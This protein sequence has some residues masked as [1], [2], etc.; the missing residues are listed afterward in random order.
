[1]STPKIQALG[2]T[3]QWSTTSWK[4]SGDVEGIGW[5]EAW[6]TELIEAMEALQPLAAQRGAE[7]AE[8]T[9]EMYTEENLQDVTPPTRERVQRVQRDR[10]QYR[11]ELALIRSQLKNPMLSDAERQALRKRWS[12]VMGGIRSC[13]EI[14]GDILASYANGEAIDRRERERDASQRRLVDADHRPPG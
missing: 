10:E 12:N 7:Q 2:I 3:Q 8:E 11:R 1:M 13:Y 4:A 5:L 14:I 6:G 9:R